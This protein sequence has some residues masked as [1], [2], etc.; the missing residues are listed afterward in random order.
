VKTSVGGID[1]VVRVIV[2]LAVLGLLLILEGNARWW[3]LVGLVPLL[4]VRAGFC[5][6]H[7]PFGISTCAAPGTP[8][9]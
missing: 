1:R 3:R 9:A 8:A 7:L 5:P 2:E 4:T 6:M